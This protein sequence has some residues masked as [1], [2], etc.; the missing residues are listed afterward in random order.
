[1]KIKLLGLLLFLSIQSFSQKGKISGYVTHLKNDPLAFT[2]VY[3]EKINKVFYTNNLGFFTIPKLN[4]GKYV[5]SYYLT[6]FTKKSDTIILDQPYLNLSK[7][8]LEELS[9]DLVY[10]NEAGVT[11]LF[12]PYLQILG[13]VPKDLYEY[14]DKFYPEDNIIFNLDN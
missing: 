7:V 14:L 3:I 8:T 4:Y 2:T 5:I 13:G 12:F 9:Y 10:T 6:G 1:M 11:G